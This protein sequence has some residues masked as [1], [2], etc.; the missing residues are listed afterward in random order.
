[1]YAAGIKLFDGNTTL[2]DDNKG[3]KQPS[4]FENH[5]YNIEVDK[6]YD[7][8]F[9]SSNTNTT[10]PSNGIEF[11]GLNASNNPINVTNNGSRLALKDGD[12]DDANASFTIDN[13]LNGNVNFAADG[14]SSVSYTHLTLPTN[15]E[16]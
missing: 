5:T 14:R 2:F 12:G 9:T 13:V 15:R 11:S 6:V 10:A 1:M 16:V 4:V 8:E 3:Y 7:V